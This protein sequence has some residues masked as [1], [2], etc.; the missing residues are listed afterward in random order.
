ML[1]KDVTA[2]LIEQKT[3]GKVIGCCSLRGPS[4]AGHMKTAIYT[5][6]DDLHFGVGAESMTLLVNYAF[7]EWERARKIYF[8]TTDAS[9]DRFDSELV[10][11]PRELTLKDHGFFRG[12]YWDFYYYSVRRD[13]WERHVAPFVNRLVG[14]A[15]TATGAG[16]G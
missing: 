6:R 10:S 15:R 9:I 16:R 12:R 8:V 1:D 13:T 3:D 5:D 11:M 4:R 2:F 14:G 7:A